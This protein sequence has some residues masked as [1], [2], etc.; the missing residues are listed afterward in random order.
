MIGW[1]GDKLA[2]VAPHQFADADFAG[3]TTTHSSTNG[4]H[5][6]IIG[7][8]TNFPI[9]GISKR[10]S[11]VSVSTPEA[12][13]VSGFY[14]MK[15]LGV[16]ALTL[17]EIL[18]DREEV[19][20]IIH[21]DNQAMIRV[22]TTN[23]N[24]SMRYLGRVHRISIPWL[25]E[26]CASEV[27]SLLYDESE[28][29]SADIY[30]KA[31][32]NKDKWRDACW[33]INT[34]DPKLL[35]ELINEA[36]QCFMHKPSTLISKP[37]V[38]DPMT[39]QPR[40]GMVLTE[41]T[42]PKTPKKA[43][44]ARARYDDGESPIKNNVQKSI[45]TN[46]KLDAQGRGCCLTLGI[47]AQIGLHKYIQL[48]QW[49]EESSACHTIGIDYDGCPS[50]PCNKGSKTP[51]VN[52]SYLVNAVHRAIKRIANA[53]Q[54][55][56]K[57]NLLNVNL[58]RNIESE[59]N[60]IPTT[61]GDF[62]FKVINLK[63]NDAM[64]EVSRAWVS[65]N[66]HDLHNGVKL[67]QKWDYYIVATY[68]DPGKGHNT[69]FPNLLN[70]LQD[71]PSSQVSATTAIP[72]RFVSETPKVKQTTTNRRIIEVCCGS[73]SLIGKQTEHSAGCEV[74]RITLE[75]DVLTLKGLELVLSHIAGPDC[76]V[77]FAFP[78]TGGCTFQITNIELGGKPEKNIWDIG[79]SL[80]SSKLRWKRF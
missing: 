16:N 63:G 17:W 48:T 7:P 57:L 29:M 58:Y 54:E 30:T 18:L 50:V 12:E 15:T 61:T 60:V 72:L 78:C 13:I 5:L 6:P 77:W 46:V 45:N 53:K 27:V 59:V 8:S 9:Q 2:D 3:C 70:E 36:S 14:A 47:N 39:P 24:P 56:F 80:T 11:C 73:E 37:T 68:V 64:V 65:D 33:L 40:G 21:E 76:L 22:V 51:T 38:E 26:R 19:T 71:F 32:R 28:N 25:H 52:N 42:T 43:I 20:P 66:P 67:D 55:Q 79:P 34:T 44:R 35:H 23:R 1:V 74:I 10:Q 69:C 62:T 41:A 75:N 4:P 49:E 31:F